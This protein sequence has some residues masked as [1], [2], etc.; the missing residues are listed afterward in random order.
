MT[1]ERILS[2]NSRKGTIVRLRFISGQTPSQ[3]NSG[4][5]RGLS[6]TTKTKGLLRTAGLC[7]SRS[8]YFFVFRRRQETTCTLIAMFEP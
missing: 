2:I 5:T 4:P 8:P 3:E 1:S 7:D 6:G